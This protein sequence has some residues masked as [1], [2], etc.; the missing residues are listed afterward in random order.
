M[1]PEDS[2]NKM[3]EPRKSHCIVLG[4]GGHTAVLIEAMRAAGFDI[5]RAILDPDPSLRGQDVL[6][7]PV[8]GGEE[9]LPKMRDQGADCFLVGLGTAGTGERRRRV[10]DYGLSC[11][12][13]PLSVVHPAAVISP[14]AQLGPG[15]QVLAGAVVHTRAILGSNVLVN[16]GAIV[17]HDCVIGDDVH[18]ATGAKLAGGVSVGDGTLIGL[19][20]CVRQG[21]HIGEMVIVAPARSWFTTLP[22]ALSLSARPPGC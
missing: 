14:S 11:R 22:T 4:G 9:L 16:C 12:L 17:E 1:L 15:C 21:I 20:A 6:G 7:V 19:G 5:A 2:R 13:E 3:P 10:F 8:I 18:I